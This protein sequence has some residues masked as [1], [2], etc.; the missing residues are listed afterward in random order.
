MKYLLALLSLCLF[1]TDVACISETSDNSHQDSSR[2]DKGPEE[3]LQP[4]SKDESEEDDGAKK[5]N[6]PPAAV[7]GRD[8]CKYKNLTVTSDRS[9]KFQSPCI[10]IY[11]KF[12]N[13]K[14]SKCPKIIKRNDRCTI[15]EIAG[16]FPTCCPELSCK[17]IED[18]VL[19][20]QRTLPPGLK[21]IL[22]EG[23]Q[24]YEPSTKK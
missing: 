15:K 19:T 16:V 23:A 9:I 7:P 20:P 14:V 17:L 11:C 3:G 22:P 13:M 4:S 24:I 5:E 2:G 18:D 12:G 6:I 21:H 10:E 8:D 1:L